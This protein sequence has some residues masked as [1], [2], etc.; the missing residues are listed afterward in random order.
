MVARSYPFFESLKHKP[1]N[2]VIVF[3]PGE[4][5]KENAP[6]ASGREMVGL[7]ETG[8]SRTPRPREAA[9]NMLQA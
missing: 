3:R 2:K 8:E 6:I 1:E 9:Q 4:E 5:R 7:V